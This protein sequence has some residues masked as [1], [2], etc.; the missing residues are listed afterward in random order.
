[1]NQDLKGAPSLQMTL[2]A[3]IS[4]TVVPDTGQLIVRGIAYTGALPVYAEVR[5]PSISLQRLAAVLATAESM[6]GARLEV[7]GSQS[8]GT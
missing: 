3:P 1:M 5:L 4:L 2:S 8:S 6:P 7:P